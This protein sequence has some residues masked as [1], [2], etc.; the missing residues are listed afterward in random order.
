M[1]GHEVLHE[2]LVGG[3]VVP[4]GLGQVEGP[5]YLE[6]GVLDDEVSSVSKNGSCPGQACRSALVVDHEGEDVEPKTTA[7]SLENQE[8]S[9]GKDVPVPSLM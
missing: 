3:D 6:E 2:P 8:K 4:V 9:L 1:R 7:E 5:L